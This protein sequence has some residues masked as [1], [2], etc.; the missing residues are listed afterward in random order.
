MKSL[1]YIGLAASI[2]T[3]FY[4]TRAYCLAF[5]GAPRLAESIIFSVREAPNVMLLPVAILA[6]LAIFGGLLG[7]TFGID[8]S[9]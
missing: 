9:S 2:L 8:P 5:T 3:G 6:V 4:L 1:F 7:F